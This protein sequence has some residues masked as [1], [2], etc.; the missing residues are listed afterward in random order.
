MNPFDELNKKLLQLNKEFENNVEEQILKNAKDYAKE[1]KSKIDDIT[2]ETDDSIEIKSENI[3]T[4]GTN[5]EHAEALEFGHR[6]ESGFVPGQH[7]FE[8]TLLENEDE[9][10]KNN[11]K[12]LKKVFK[13]L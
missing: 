8:N 11:E 7:M 4:V 9:Y 12:V 13:K 10:N 2:G 5:I 3:T 1:V 6:T